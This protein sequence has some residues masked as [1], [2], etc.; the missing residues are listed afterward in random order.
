MQ[1]SGSFPADRIH[2]I[3]TNFIPQGREIFVRAKLFIFLVL[4]IPSDNTV[5]NFIGETLGNTVSDDFNSD[6]PNT[7][8][9]PSEDSS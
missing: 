9:S 3:P 7:Q 6:L 8:R 4:S 5:Y 1:S 2:S